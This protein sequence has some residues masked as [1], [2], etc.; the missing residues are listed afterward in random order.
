MSDSTNDPNRHGAT[1]LGGR[2][3]DA[4]RFA[5]ARQ[6]SGYVAMVRVCPACA[7]EN[8]E[9]NLFCAQCA[10]PLRNVV[11]RPASSESAG[12][13]LLRY[14]L[15]IE[16]RALQRNRIQAQQG[17]TGTIIVG[18]IMLAIGSWISADLLWQVSTWTV[19]MALAISGLWKLRT[20]AIALRNWGVILSVA[21]LGLLALFTSNSLAGQG[22]DPP[23]PSP[24]ITP[25][26]AVGTGATPSTDLNASVPVYRGDPQHTGIQPGPNPFGTP[27]LAWRFDTGGEV[28]SSPIIANSTLFIASKSGYLFALDAVTGSEI[29]RFQLSDYVVRS[30]PTV[31]DGTVYVGAGF[32]F[33]A[34]DAGSGQE[35]WR[36]P[37]RYAG[38]SSPVIANDTL[39]VTSQE[40]WIYAIGP[41]DGKEKWKLSTDGLPFG[42][43][44][45]NGKV[46]IVG[47]DAGTVHCVDITNGRSCW[48]AR[49]DDGI[50]ASAAMSDSQVILVSKSG[51]TRGLNLKDGKVLWTVNTGGTEPVAIDATSAYISGA[52]GAITSVSLTDGVPQWTFPTG[53]T[54]SG[55]PVISGDLVI[56]GTGRN[57]VALEK[58]TG[59][60]IWNYLAGGDIGT[61]PAAIGGYVFFG[62]EDGFVYAISGEP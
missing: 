48:Q 51:V 28:Y 55:A 62:S 13:E 60:Q 52:D 34:I 18:T 19:G 25:A 31:V 58:T 47:T 3:K 8:V 32:N 12:R 21:I 26:V 43:I 44:A 42:S 45:T 61:S 20:D 15:G 23:L 33:F 22:A 1:P 24:S 57:L 46:A 10:Q 59:N 35:R 38:Q 5:I 56:V 30:T 36:F 49:T 14:R 53:R 40:G 6:W 39:L 27:R 29:W 17:G 50:F 7:H 9:R 2:P 37:M 54:V 4:R 11:P 16:Q 41:G